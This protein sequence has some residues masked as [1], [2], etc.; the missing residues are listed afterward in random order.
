MDA[1]LLDEHL[2]LLLLRRG[3]K[4]SIENVAGLYSLIY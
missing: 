3:R 2:L 4:R 1:F